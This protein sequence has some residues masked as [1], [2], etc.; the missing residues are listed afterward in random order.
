[1]LFWKDTW[2]GEGSF[3]SR[4]PRLFDLAMDKD[5]SGAEK[6]RQRWERAERVGDGVEVSWDGG[7]DFRGMLCLAC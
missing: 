3:E 7:R 5:I 1:V 6:C 2:A 4:F